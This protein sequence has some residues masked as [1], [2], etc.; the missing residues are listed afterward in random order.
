MTTVVYLSA[1]DWQ[2]RWA[3]PPLA[4]KLPD[5][6]CYVHHT[7]GGQLSPDAATAFRALNDYA[8]NVKGY[9]A[10]DYDVLVHYD[11]ARDVLTIGEGR[12]KWLSAATLDRNEQGEAVCVI[13]NF[14]ARVPYPAEVEGTAR[15][16]V[17]GIEQGW[18]SSF[19]TILPHRDNP[20]HPGATACC[21]R[22][23]IAQLP[24]IRA[25]VAELLTPQP[26]EDDM[27][28]YFCVE[29][30]GSADD[31]RPVW[32]TFDGRIAYR[33]PGRLGV[34]QGVS[35]EIVSR[36]EAARRYIL[37]DTMEAIA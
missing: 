8:I 6:E 19:A 20:A 34:P 27:P 28:I 4:E 25:R 18:I 22:F 13:G 36:A 26:P 35:I 23:L 29:R 1:A 11:P 10:L 37:V 33:V 24:V 17:Y 3:R 14:E 32:L 31:P 12:G 2:M 15:G 7:G 5:P 21:G 9:S 30:L 16:I